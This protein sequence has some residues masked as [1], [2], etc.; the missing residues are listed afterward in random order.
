[1]E[2][3]NLSPLQRLERALKKKTAELGCPEV[4]DEGAEA[5]IEKVI[6]RRLDY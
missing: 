2:S 4:T 1:M 3:E 6:G 5:V